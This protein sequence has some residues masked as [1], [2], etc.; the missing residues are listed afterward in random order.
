MPGFTDNLT[1]G[2]DY[3]FEVIAIDRQGIR[4]EAATIMLRTNEAVN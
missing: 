3:T 1:P 4:S 2:T